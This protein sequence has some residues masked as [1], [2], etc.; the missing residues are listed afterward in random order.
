MFAL[1]GWFPSMGP[2]FL[3][4]KFPLAIAL[5]LL[6]VL[7]FAAPK[8]SADSINLTSNN[9]GIPG[10]IGTVSLTQSGVNQVTV[11]ITMNPGFTIKLQGGD[12]FFNSSLGLNASNISGITVVAGG[13]TYTGLM[14]K[15]QFDKNASTFG[16][17]GDRLLN[18]KNGPN[19]ITS[20]DKLTFV[21]TAP[22]L[23]VA[24]LETANSQGLL[25]AIHFCDVSGTNCGT[26]TGFAAG[27]TISTVPEP[28]SM[29]L[30][31][32]GL[33]GIAGMVRRRLKR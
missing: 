1:K 18:F 25:F 4:L 7:V 12:V 8:A 33:V 23:T 26:N 13:N 2:C 32:T 14:D 29:T 10:S 6:A 17:F 16:K 21:I 5:T 28:G 31:G 27:G 30:L 20:A 9:L 11:S 15:M 19:G 22:G 24:S 3:K